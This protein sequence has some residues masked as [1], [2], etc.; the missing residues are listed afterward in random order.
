MRPILFNQCIGQLLPFTN[1]VV[2]L[3]FVLAVVKYSD[4][5]FFVRNLQRLTYTFEC[6]LHFF[7]LLLHMLTA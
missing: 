7:L 1:T 4:L 6:Q 2:C 3:I 5:K